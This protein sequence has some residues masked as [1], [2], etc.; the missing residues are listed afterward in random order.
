V[1]LIFKFIPLRKILSLAGFFIIV[2]LIFSSLS[3][4]LA[5]KGS[6]IEIQK[7]NNS[8]IDAPFELQ[9][10]N[11]LK[12]VPP[13]GQVQ[14]IRSLLDKYKPALSIQYPA[15]DEI[16]MKGPNEKWE[17][18]LNLK[19]WP[20]AEDPE[21]GL[22]PHIIV[23]IDNSQPIRISHAEEKSRIVIPMNGLSPGSH[24][25]AAYAVYPW[26][27][28]VKRP[29]AYTQ[30][31]VHFFKE[32]KGTQ[33]SMNDIWLTV[34]SPSDKSYKEPLL[35][36]SLIWNAPIQGLEEGDDRWRLKVSINGD[37]FLIDHLEGV[38]I[39]GIPSNTL[40][41]QFELLDNVGN[42]IGPAFNNQLKLISDSSIE[43]PLWLQSGL[44]QNKLLRFIGEPKISEQIPLYVNQ[45]GLEN[46]A[47]SLKEEDDPSIAEY[48]LIFPRELQE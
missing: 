33:P 20:L 44:N 43:K 28:A 48:E 10:I 36:D 31:R 22:G 6:S 38:W 3:P 32:L 24:R 7:Q 9:A 4:V 14:Q 35:I 12:E 27:E 25:I 30:S 5:I 21:L 39:K 26:G 41:I 18:I 45:L 15:K 19:D 8:V 2:L 47:S 23:Q 13:P 17:L 40:T 16:L 1:N 37:S 29:G 46:H 42:P 11:S 34:T